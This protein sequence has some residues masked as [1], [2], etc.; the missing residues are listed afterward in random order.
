MKLTVIIGAVL[1]SFGSLNAQNKTTDEISVRPLHTAAEDSTA[2]KLARIA[3]SNTSVAIQQDN[4]NSA[5]YE[6]SA[7]KTAWL[8]NFRASGN[9]NEFTIKGRTTSPY[10]NSLVYPRYNV[11]VTVPL[12]LFFNQPKQVKAQYYKYQA[13]VENLKREKENLRLLVITAYYDYLRNQ[14]LFELQEEVL[15]DAEFA[16]K[17]SEE[18]F[19]KGEINVEVYT[20]VNKRYNSEKV[21]KINLER[22]LIVSQAE[23]ETL[24][25]MPL[26]KAIAMSMPRR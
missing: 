7:T 22:D 21:T 2:E 15:Q 16:F 3:M 10:G 24:I 12:G 18:K 14:R 19:Q 25:G 4:V 5:K 23:L 26:S 1:F 6:L 17:K 13:E 9:V 20:A 8:D 11:G